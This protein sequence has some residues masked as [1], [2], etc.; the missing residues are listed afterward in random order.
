MSGSGS[1]GAVSAAAAGWA[2]PIRADA[3][4]LPSG[5]Q[6]RG[7]RGDQNSRHDAERDAD[8]HF[9]DVGDQHL[10]ADEDEHHRQ[11]QLQETELVDDAGEQE[12]SDRSPRMAQTFEV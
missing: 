4:A 5:R 12:M 10:A 6:R 8:R 9:E 11:A 7:D 2:P 3:P 1:I